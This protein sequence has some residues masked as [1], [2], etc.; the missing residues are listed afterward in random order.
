M[1]LLPAAAAACCAADCGPLTSQQGSRRTEAA[2]SSPNFDA[3]S[4][5]PAGA[6]AWT[7]CCRH[8]KR[9]KS[10]GP[11]S[12]ETWRAQQRSK[13]QQ[14]QQ[15]Q[16]QQQ[17]RGLSGL[18]AAPSRDVKGLFL[19]L[20]L[21]F[22]FSFSLPFFASCC[23]SMTDAEAATAS[24]ATTPSSGE[25]EDSVSPDA[26]A[27]AAAAAAA[28]RRRASAAAA[29]ASKLP[30]ASQD[31]GSEAAAAAAAAESSQARSSAAKAAAKAAANE[32]ENTTNC[33]CP[34]KL[35]F[36]DPNSDIAKSPYRG[37]AT[38]LFICSAFYLV[39]NPVMRWY[40]RGEYFDTSLA[41]S[42]FYDFFYLMFMWFK[43]TVWS[44]TAYLLHVL[45]MKNW[46]GRRTL[47]A[48]QHFTQCAAIAYAVGHCLYHKW[49]IIPA[50][51][52]QVAA[53][54]NFMKMHSYTEINLEFHRKR[55]TADAC[56]HYPG[57]INLPN[58]FYYM[59]VPSLVYEP[60]FPRGKGFRPAYFVWKLI[61]LASA[62]TVMYL[63]CTSYLI[64]T[65]SRSPQVSLLEAIFSLIFPFLFLDLLIFFIL[66]ECICNLLAEITNFANRDFY[67]DW[68]NSTNWDE[69]SRKWNRPVHKFLL[70]HVYMETQQ[71]YRWSQRS[72]ALATF[73]FSALLHEMIMAVCLRFVRFYLFALMLLQIPLVALGRYYTHNRCLA[74]AIFWACMLLGVPLLA[75]AYGREFA[76][77]HFYM[78][79]G[80]VPAAAAQQ[81]QQQQQQ[82]PLL[83]LLQQASLPTKGRAAAGPATET[84]WEQQAAAG[85]AAASRACRRRSCMRE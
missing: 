3:A 54:C 52:V 74:N 71:K 22:S 37:F 53:V 12:A 33:C 68:W 35:D 80:W 2:T 21:V 20:L 40:E 44:L 34:S 46:I 9:A 56:K 84:G 65:I 36:F 76:Q 83:L 27:A 72:A 13:L 82:Q 85:R 39:A 63:A 77:E 10:R 64:P 81:E 6:A 41:V 8:L 67:H 30:K 73:L 42:M 29:A 62:M 23:C 5:S 28:R 15:Q 31:G 14:Q 59:V 4:P 7:A 1:L 26:P 11:I 55:N 57:N 38:L 32:I 24:P 78:V 50:A 45:F 51:F 19:L 70:R 75:V 48:L 16:L 66:F 43:L 60:Q 79:A 61:S 18:G 25:A 58:F 47:F 69:Y 49:P 17:Q